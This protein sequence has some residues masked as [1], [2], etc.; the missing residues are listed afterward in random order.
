MS[1]TPTPAELTGQREQ[2]YLGVDTLERRRAFDH[3]VTELRR[4]R[5]VTHSARHLG[6]L[7]EGSRQPGEAV[8]GRR[9][10]TELLE[11]VRDGP[12]VFACR[13]FRADDGRRHPHQGVVDDVPQSDQCRGDRRGW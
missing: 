1:D 2:W 12:N 8:C 5:A 13:Q 4:D 9:R 6:C 10:H 7:P 11:Y 3:R